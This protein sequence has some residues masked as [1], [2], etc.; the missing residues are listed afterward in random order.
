M[1]YHFFIFIFYI[2]KKKSPTNTGNN[3][4]YR[5]YKGGVFLNQQ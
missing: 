5:K 3:K 4:Y 2:D 1:P